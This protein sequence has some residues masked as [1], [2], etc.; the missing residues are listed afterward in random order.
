MKNILKYLALPTVI[1]IV[2]IF[3][4]T[5]SEGLNYWLTWAGNRA[6]WVYSDS[7]Y[8]YPT[9]PIRM[10]Q[11]DSLKYNGVTV[12]SGTGGGGIAAS[13]N[14]SF[15]GRNT[16]SD[17]WTFNDSAKFT[18]IVNMDSAR[19]GVVYN[20]T[21]KTLT[22]SNTHY[23]LEQSHEWQ[24]LYSTS[25]MTLDS[26]NGFGLPR[27]KI[28]SQTD[29]I[30]SDS[31]FYFSDIVKLTDS[32]VLSSV[33]I[34][35]SNGKGLNWG[36]TTGQI[37]SNAGNLEYR[38]A[39]H[40]FNTVYGNFLFESDS[41]TGFNVRR[42]L[43]GY[44][45]TVTSASKWEFSDF[46]KFTAIP[47]IASF[48]QDVARTIQYYLPNSASDTLLTRS[49]TQTVTN[50]TI[51]GS[52]N[53]I[54]GIKSGVIVSEPLVLS[55]PADATT[56]YFGGNSTLTPTTSEGQRRIYFPVACTIKSAI[57]YVYVVGGSTA[58]NI[59]YSIRKNATTDSVITA[60][61]RTSSGSAYNVFSNYNMGVVIA[62]GDWIE[63]KIVTPTWVTNPTS[64][65]MNATIYFE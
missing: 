43:E 33:D 20:G 25:L 29:S 13:D 6:A 23:N 39:S 44:A 59:T 54:T 14:I 51:S 30:T 18:R 35:A 37:Y 50:K 22:A 56:Y 9:L 19:I 5:N 52:S 17:L 16:T 21:S 1:I 11:G 48:Y 32:L 57:I 12:T 53:T 10:K 46:V 49:Q 38:S 4:V 42:K 65:Y 60:V 61:G 7:G 64:M 41:A 24:T 62:Q 36:E 2:L 40:N 34:F 47:T 31:K 8:I 27:K 55:A 63:F 45:D 3:T 58:E 26:L 28:Y 15:S